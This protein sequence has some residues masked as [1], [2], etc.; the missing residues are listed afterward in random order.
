MHTSMKT[1][2]FLAIIAT[3]SL[4]GTGCSKVLDVESQTKP[5]TEFLFNSPEGLS[6]AII[7]LYPKDRTIANDNE[8]ELY[9]VLMFDYCTDLMVFRG[10]TAATFARLDNFKTSLAQFGNYWKQLYQIIGKANEIIKAAKELGLENPQVAQAYGEACCFRAKSYFLLYQRYERLY[11]NTEPTTIDNAFGRTFRAASKEEIFTQ[12]K[13]DLEEA[14]KYLDWTPVIGVSGNPDYGRMTKAVATHLRAQVAMWENDW[15]GAITACESLFACPSY[16]LMPTAADVFNG[17]E[18][19]SKE[20]IY[21]FQFSENPGGGASVSGGVAAG[22]RI[23]L[24]V[25]PNYKKIT[26]M[27]NSSDNGGYGWGRVYPNSY[28]LSLFDKEKDNRYSTLFQHIFTYNNKEDLPAGKHIGDTLR[29]NDGFTSAQYLESAHPF[30]LKHADKWT[31]SDNPDR[32]SSF[33]DAIVYRLAETYLIAAEAYFHKEG[34]NSTKA[35]EYFN[36]TYTRAGNDTFTAPLTLDII[37]DEYARELHFEGV[38]WG[39]LKRLGLLGER[40]R[41]H[42]GDTKAEDPNLNADYAQARTNFS[43]SRDWRWPIPQAEIDLMPGFGQNP[44]WN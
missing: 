26:G 12:I 33:R 28:L 20:V 40:V 4:V 24:I 25:T 21:A 16:G 5:T 43:D 31:N 29:L 27:K 38:R 39:L 32:T 11:L 42:A 8:A 30:T 3:L 10:G 34:A 18:Y 6:K 13:A 14:S 1:K 37:L 41:L 15:D 2:I 35:H 19:R 9:A 7:G 23:S 36:K 17:R 22:H 44:G